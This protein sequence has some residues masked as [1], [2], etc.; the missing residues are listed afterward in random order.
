MLSL[1]VLLRYYC[2]MRGKRDGWLTDT[3]F[4]SWTLWSPWTSKDI[5]VPV[6]GLAASLSSSPAPIGPT[7]LFLFTTVPTTP[8][9]NLFM[10][11]WVSFLVTLPEPAVNNHGNPPQSS[12]MSHLRCIWQGIYRHRPCPLPVNVFG[13]NS[14]EPRHILNTATQ[15]VRPQYC[16]YNSEVVVLTLLF[17][18]LALSV[19]S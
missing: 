19:N 4:L 10:G 1:C 12:L 6:F 14:V 13:W 7:S 18:K 5:K 8:H 15:G 11:F 3:V 2:V 9:L 16:L 17:T